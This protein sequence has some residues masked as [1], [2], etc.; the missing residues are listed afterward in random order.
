MVFADLV[1][2]YEARKKNLVLKLIGISLTFLTEAKELHRID[3]LKHPTP[4]E[5]MSNPGGR[6]KVRTSRSL[7]LI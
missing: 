1:K 7:L 4:R 5:I 2:L 3:F 6:L